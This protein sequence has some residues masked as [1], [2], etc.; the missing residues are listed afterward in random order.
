MSC[1]LMGLL[2]YSLGLYLFYFAAILVYR[3]LFH[4]LVHIP[5]PTIARATYLYEWYYDLYLSGQYTFKLKELHK[6]YGPV[7]RINPD[8]VHIDDPDFFDEVYNQTNGRAEK[9]PQVAEAFGPYPA[10]IGTQ[11]HALHRVR[12]SALN[13]FFPKKAVNDLIPAMNR[14]IGSLCD[15]LSDASRSG[16]TLNMKYIF[17]AVTLD[18]INNCCFSR[19]PENIIKSDFGREGFDDVDSFLEASLLNIH[20]PWLMRF[21][22]SLPDSAYKDLSRQAEDIRHGRD[23]TYEKAGHRTV[24]HELLEST[25]PPDEL[26]RDR[27]RDEAFSLVTAG[28]GT[29]AYVLRGTAYYIAANPSVRKQ[30]YHGLKAAIPDP[31]IQPPLQ[32]L[33]KLPYLSAIVQECLRLCNPVTHR[34]GRQFPDKTL[35]CQGY[36][37][38]AGTTVGMTAFLTHQNASIFPKPEAF[39]PGGWLSEDRKRLERYLIPFNRG[40]RSCLGINLA[41]AELFLI[42]AA[43]FRQV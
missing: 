28:S 29:T 38:P 19:E 22:Y 41:R 24:F 9:H 34:I 21:S 43:V 36:V 37:V 12:R 5:G 25:L 14:P 33:E 18:I 26:K 16:E 7:I 17:A 8:E 42:L 1:T 32:E 27:L 20:I 30:L 4:P 2:T 11:W 39:R 40:T 13:Y 15:R 23:R 31:S 35:T 6:R 10:T 3:C